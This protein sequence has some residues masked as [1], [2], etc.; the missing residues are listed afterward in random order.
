M[1][2]KEVPDWDWSHDQVGH[3]STTGASGAGAS[4]VPGL[5]TPGGSSSGFRPTALR[6]GRG[7]GGIAGPSRSL[8]WFAASLAVVAL[9]LMPAAL[10]LPPISVL[11]WLLSG[12]VSAGLASLWSYREAQTSTSLSSL[13]TEQALLLRF[14]VLGLSVVAVLGHSYL[15]AD[16]VSRR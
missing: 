9:A 3:S 8:L 10:R 2:E 14:I 4:F 12:F 13:R 1:P 6:V 5:T 16:W 7:R 15:V 11:G